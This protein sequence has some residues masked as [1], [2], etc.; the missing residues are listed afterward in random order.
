ML[1]RWVEVLWQTD[2]VDFNANTSACQRTIHPARAVTAV[3][4]EPPFPR[5]LPAA[6]AAVCREGG[7][8]GRRCDAEPRTATASSASPTPRWTPDPLSDY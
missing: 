7:P 5:D 3:A 2:E 8:D 4:A 1:L 6:P